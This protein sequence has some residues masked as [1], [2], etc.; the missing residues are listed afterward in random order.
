MISKRI[1]LRFATFSCKKTFHRYQSL[2]NR[3]FR[4]GYNRIEFAVKRPET[5]SSSDVLGGVYMM[6][7]IFPFVLMLSALG[8]LLAGCSQPAAEGDAGKTGETAGAT[9]GGE[10]APEGEAG[11]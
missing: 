7:K 2:D 8:V 5:T 1:K 9:G 3:E 11:K 6:K 10:K 4:C